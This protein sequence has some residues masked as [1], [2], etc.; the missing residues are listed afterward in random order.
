M[1]IPAC[2]GDGRVFFEKLVDP[3]VVRSQVKDVPVVIIVEPTNPGFVHACTIEDIESTLRLLPSEHIEAISAFVLRQPKRKEQNLSP[4]W[5]RFAYWSD[6]REHSG[7]MIYLESQE[8]GRP[9]RWRKSLRPDGAAELERLRKDGHQID[10]DGRRYAIRTTVETVRNTQ[11]YRTLP[12]EVGHHV[13][14]YSKV[15]QPAGECFERWQELDKKYCSRPTQEREAFAHRYAD[16]F[17]CRERENGTLPFD[18]KIDNE[19]MK[20]LGIGVD[21]FHLPIETAR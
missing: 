1:V 6:V 14:Y 18:R 2:F 15:D 4:V 7:P 8:I 19:R 13:D 5:G 9:F 12:H 11:L 3:V 17:S 20:K 16:E 21:W 10:F